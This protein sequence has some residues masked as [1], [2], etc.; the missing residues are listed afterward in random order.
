MKKTASLLNPQANFFKEI[1]IQQPGWWDLLCD[2]K[3]LYIEVRKDNSVNVYY[4]GGSIARI[5][6]KNGFSAKI[7]QKYLGDLKPRLATKKGV[8]VYGYDSIDLTKLDDISLGEI[9]N[10]IKSNYIRHIDER[11]SSEKISEK[12]IQG[13]MIKENPNYI[14]SEFQFN[15][16]TDIGKLRID[17]IEL[18]EGVLSFVELKGISDNRLKNDPLR[19]LNA[20][21]I[22]TQMEMYRLFINKY[23]FDIIEYYKKLLEIK[24]FLGLTTIKSQNFTLNKIPKLIIAD[25]Y[26]RMTPNRKKRIDHIKRLLESHNINYEIIKWK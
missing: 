25:T 19:N 13:K 20:P 18:S 9:K 1:I 4:F 23:E 6:Y 8:T 17:L 22:I 11:N 16:D 10:H 24:R 21:E 14:D 26:S 5:A 7:H 15:K 12:Y 2:D 3:E